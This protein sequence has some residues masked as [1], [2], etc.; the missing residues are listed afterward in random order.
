MI[1]LWLTALLVLSGCSNTDKKASAHKK[2]TLKNDTISAPKKPVAVHLQLPPEFQTLLRREMRQIE[3][4]MQAL[5]AHLAQGKAD[6]AE[7]MARRI[8]NSFILKQ[9]LSKQELKQLVK[10][11]PDDFVKRDRAFHNRA[12]KLARAAGGKNLQ[13]GTKIFGEMVAGCVGCHS[14]YATNRFPGLGRQQ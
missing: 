12:K 14:R 1:G 9:E 11:L 3:T 5:L 6:K 10:L 4:G 7:A 2:V 13:A 8:H